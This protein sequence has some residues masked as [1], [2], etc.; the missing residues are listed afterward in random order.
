MFDEAVLL[1]GSLNHTVNGYDNNK[2]HLFRI[3]TA[4]A[5]AD[6]IK[7]FRESWLKAEP[8]TRTMIDEALTKRAEKASRPRRPRSR[9]QSVQRSLSA[10]LTALSDDIDEVLEEGFE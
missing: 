5:V 2:E 3:T 9:S 4:E 8:V 7:D 1:T 6:V 10:E